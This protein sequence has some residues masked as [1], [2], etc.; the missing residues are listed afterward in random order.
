MLTFLGRYLIE[1]QGWTPATTGSFIAVM[2]LVNLAA[3]LSVGPLARMG[4]P[5]IAGLLAAFCDFWRQRRSAVCRP[6][7]RCG[8]YR[9]RQHCDD[10]FRV[11]AGAGVHRRAAH[12]PRSGTRCHDLWRHCAI[13]NLGTF[14]GTPLYA[15]AF[16]Q[17]GWP[18]GV[19]F[20]LA[21]TM[22]GLAA[23]LALGMVLKT[24]T[25]SQN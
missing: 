10:R 6:T 7:W 15:Y 19:A 20:V 16:A 3:T 5:L 11:D 13:G 12:C 18:G 14:S 8:R 9:A 17:A 2:T 21:V 23:S 22:A 1:V 25:V 4:L 24:V